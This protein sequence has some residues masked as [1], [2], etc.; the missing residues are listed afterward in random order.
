MVTVP[1]GWFKM[2][3]DLSELNERPEHDVF[4]DAFQ[5]DKYEVS[6]SDFASFLNE[7]GNPEN[8][9]F[10]TD[11]YSTIAKENTSDGGQRYIPRKGFENY[12]ANNVS[13]YGADAYCRWK[14]KRLPYEAEWEKAARGNDGRTYPWDSGP[15]D[16]TKARYGQKW[17]EKGLQVM[18]PVDAMPGGASYY[19]V[20]KMTGNCREWVVDWYRQNYC[21]YC[22]PDSAD[23]TETALKIIGSDREGEI[24]NKK[25]PDMPPKYDPKGPPVGSFKVLRGGSWEET[26]ERSLRSSYRYWLDPGERRRDTGFRCAK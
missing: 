24:R 16:E 20:F 19:G 12:P 13:W 4:V 7:K 23:Y 22:D 14:E 3:T 6:A 26:D 8:K 11:E 10:S 5:M 21:N 17:D 2:G 18:V 25:G 9:Y 1:G 15:P